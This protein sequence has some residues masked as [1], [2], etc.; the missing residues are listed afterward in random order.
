[1]TFSRFLN[2][3]GL[4]ALTFALN[5]NNEF[6]GI[7]L[8]AF[9][10]DF[11]WGTA[12]A[13]YQVEGAVNVSGRGLSIWDTFS[14]IPGKID[15]NDNGDVADNHYFLYKSDI[16][17]MKKIGFKAFRISLSWSRIFPTGL[18]P[19][20]QAG[21]D[22]YNDVIN[23]L[24]ANGIT[25]LVTLYHWDLPQGLEDLGG[26]LNRS[27]IVEAF[28]IYADTCFKN[29]GDRVKYWLTINEPMS[30]T[31]I[32]YDSGVN[33]P[34][35]CSDRTRCPQG[36][37]ATEPY[38]VTHNMLL[39][40]AVAVQTYRSKYQL[41]Q[42]G[43]IGI[44]LNIDWSVPFNNTPEDHAA[45]ERHLVFQTG[46]F[47]DPVY[48][49]DY[50]DIMKHLVGNRLPT[51]TEGE[52]LLLRG[53]HDFFGLNHYTS[54]Y[55][56][57]DPNPPKNQG[58]G[59]DQAAKIT[60]VRNGV[61]IGIPA[62]SPWLYVVPSGMREILH[63]VARRYENDD[64][65]I[66]ENGCDV[67]NESALPLDQALNDTFRINYYNGYIAEMSRAIDEGVKVKAYFAWSLMD[68]FEWAN[69]YAKR[70]GIHYVDYK[71][72][73][74]RYPKNSAVWF[75]NLIKSLNG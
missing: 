69:G 44:T 59:A 32:G 46:W 39:S 6:E 72:N 63:W 51:F 75:G 52:K 70:F 60:Q 33:A 55:A 50:P 18:P 42:G 48:F 67:P 11:L 19:V 57:N 61:P 12:T 17:L 31:L 28:N 23:E 20:N 29:F 3:L 73:L 37:S 15:N 34:G 64:I 2:F 65:Y 25:P 7:N 41:I 1:M 36:N 8:K 16:Q 74:T 26:W 22:H 62:D 40:H 66:T 30:V 45:A 56:Q 71:N 58:W 24:V 14:H 4:L 35:R 49:G 10:P 47:G 68:N 54:V 53:S 5:A 38:I 27:L 21:I 9:P 13:S 43:K